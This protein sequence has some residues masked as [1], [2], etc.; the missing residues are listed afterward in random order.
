[1]TAARLDTRVLDASMDA[2]I[3]IDRAGS[4][5]RWNCAAATMFGRSAAEV[6]GRELAATIV[7]EHLRAAHREGLRQ[8]STSGQL[9]IPGGRTETVGQRA[10]GSLFPVELTITRV[11][12]DDG[13]GGVVFVG[14]LRDITERQRMLAD[15]LDSRERLLNVSDDTRRRVER[16]LHDGAQQQLVALAMSLAAARRKIDVDPAAGTRLLDQS[17]AILASAIDELREL[18]RGVHSAILTERGLGAAVIHLARRSPIDVVATVDPFGR[19]PQTVETS[20]YYLVTEALTNATKYGAH[21]VTVDVQLMPG[22]ATAGPSLVCLISDDGPGGADPRKGTGLA[23]MTERLAVLGGTVDI[24]SGPGRG[25]TLR[26][27]V[28]L[29]D[30]DVPDAGVGVGALV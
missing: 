7:P 26:I 6:E 3:T 1:M 28:P 4:I 16:D 30:A 5:L 12:D 23:G 13:D 22:T 29:A 8:A 18:A 24:D 2:V 27:D 21:R 17:S 11:A 19:L 14:F 9:G 20:V 25:T 15:L 10:D